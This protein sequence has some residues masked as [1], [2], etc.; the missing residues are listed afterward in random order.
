MR[1]G[2]TPVITEAKLRRIVRDE[3]A[4]QY[5]VQEG[6]LDSLSSPFKK[7]S[8]KAK[9]TVASK[10]EEA[11][12]KIKPYLQKLSNIESAKT[13]LNNYTSQ[14]GAVPLKQ[15]VSTMNLDDLRSQAEKIKDMDFKTLA[16]KKSKNSD[17]KEGMSYYDFRMSLILLEEEHNQK[18]GQR[19]LNESLI[20]AGVALWWASVKGFVGICGVANL[21]LSIGIKISKFTGLDDLAWGLE[22][23]KKFVHKIEEF[24]LEKVAFPKPVQYAAYRA[25]HFAK[26]KIDKVKKKEGPGEALSY[27]HF[28]SPEGKEERE[29]ALT[30]LKM[31]IIVS[32]F[33]EALQ[34]IFHGLTSLLKSFSEASHHAGDIASSVQHAGIEGAELTKTAK[35]VSRSAEEFAAAA[36]KTP[37]AA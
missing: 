6:L 19:V 1:T 23:L 10:A 12:E 25:I 31:A 13:F 29:A 34:H 20:A 30:T 35:A 4:R 3:L 37:K 17:V 28:L 9:K 2:K 32:L 16:S 7:L 26:D 27:D 33:A 14:E 5:L 18:Y 24:A 15:L 22:K 36:G 8:D 21:V 11:I